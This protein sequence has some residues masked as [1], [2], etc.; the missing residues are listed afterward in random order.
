MFTLTEQFNKVLVYTGI[1]KYDRDTK[2]G[3]CAG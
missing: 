2:G 1:H 3:Y